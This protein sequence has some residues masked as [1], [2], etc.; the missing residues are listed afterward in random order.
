MNNMQRLAC[1][2]NQ[3]LEEENTKSRSRLWR[4]AA[5]DNR[6]LS[7]NAFFAQCLRWKIYGSLIHRCFIYCCYPSN[8]SQ[9]II[10]SIFQNQRI[11]IAA[12][13][14][15]HL[16]KGLKTF[17]PISAFLYKKNVE[18]S[19]CRCDNYHREKDQRERILKDNKARVATGHYGILIIIRRT[20]GFNGEAA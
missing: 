12:I 9:S 20:I 16:L 7:H 17:F 1:S 15:F 18:G 4:R 14:G 6:S 10:K 11:T 3:A 19:C 13:V 8:P 5:M 2:T